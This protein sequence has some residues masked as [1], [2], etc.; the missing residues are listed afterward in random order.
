METEGPA[1]LIALPGWQPLSEP[2][3]RSGW[4]SI[5]RSSHPPIRLDSPYGTPYGEGR[6]HSLTPEGQAPS[7]AATCS[8]CH[9]ERSVAKSRNLAGDDRSILLE[10]RFLRCTML[11]IVPVGMTKQAMR[12]DFRK[13]YAAQRAGLSSIM[14]KSR[15]RR[16]Q[17]IF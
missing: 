2:S 14:V 7:V 9:F 15:Q 4:F 12:E 5:L 10:R 16:H 3:E 13:T 1:F 11:R 6:L 8:F 17:E